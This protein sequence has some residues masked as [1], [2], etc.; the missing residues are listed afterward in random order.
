MAGWRVGFMVGNA[1]LI[2]ALEKIKSWLNDRIRIAPHSGIGE[3]IQNILQTA[4][5]LYRQTD[6][7]L[8]LNRHPILVK[9]IKEKI[10][11]E[12]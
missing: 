9:Y 1:K 5:L 8:T 11:K 6:L 4:E 3:E 12:F 10:E 7:Y 2:G